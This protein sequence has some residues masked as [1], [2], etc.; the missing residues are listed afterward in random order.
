MLIFYFQ[1]A[2]MP[3]IDGLI[4]TPEA[5]VIVGESLTVECVANGIPHPEYKWR[6][7][8]EVVSIFD[9]F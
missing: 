4:A 5:T 6:K 2:Y 1:V 8:L 7:I 9:I 3:T